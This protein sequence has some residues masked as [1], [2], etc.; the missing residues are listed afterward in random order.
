MQEALTEVFLNEFQKNRGFWQKMY[1]LGWGLWQDIPQRARD[2]LEESLYSS[3]IV[4]DDIIEKAVTESLGYPRAQAFSDWHSVPI[5]S[6]SFGQV[7][8]AT[9]ST[10]E[11]VAVKVQYP[12]AINNLKRD[13]RTLKNL[14]PI[15]EALYPQVGVSSM[16]KYLKELSELELN[17]EQEIRT[18]ATM[19][20]VFSD[21]PDIVVPKTYRSFSN[22]KMITM[23]YLRGNNGKD[24]CESASQSERNA[25]GK[26]LVF[27]ALAPLIRSE[28]F[29]YE[30]HL[31]NLVFGEDFL[32]LTDFG[33]IA[34]S[35]VNHRRIFFEGL[36]NIED[37][38]FAS[39]KQSY[40]DLG[41]TD[42][43][44]DI[45]FEAEIY[46]HQQ[47]LLK[48]FLTDETMKLDHQEMN[49]MFEYQTKSSPNIGKLK[50][51]PHMFPM[52]KFQWSKASTLGSLRPEANWRAVI[53]PLL[54][55][56]RFQLKKSA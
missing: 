54:D 37:E 18:M 45:D 51:V 1:Q 5:G 3:Y 46:A 28:F 49:K 53:L 41:F 42:R 17:Y 39:F 10:G 43:I 29:L 8:R 21:R 23:Q 36:A 16:I 55:E 22:S 48:P 47:Y 32:G 13:L 6:G 15:L 34:P 12:D 40:V 31:G 24:F 2:N 11:E 26:R 25:M 9:L 19:A 52:M 56:Y 27:A 20:D 50:L 30:V 4:S 33:A 35:C 38:D 44:E 14:A 7:H